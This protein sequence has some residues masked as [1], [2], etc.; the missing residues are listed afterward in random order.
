MKKINLLL[1]PLGIIALTFTSCTKEDILT[2]P[3]AVAASAAIEAIN[4]SDIQTGTQINYDNSG[5]LR[6]AKYTTSSCATIS[7]E[8]PTTTFPKTYIVDYGTGCT[9]NNITRKGKIKITFSNYITETGSTMTIQRVNYYVNDK[10]VEGKIVYK[11]TTTNATIPQW[12]RTVTDGKFTDGG[13]VFLNSGTHTTKQTAGASTLSLDDNTYE[14]TEGS[15]T[16]SKENESGI[17]LTVSEP[18]VK[19]HSCS[20]I[21]KGKLTITSKSLNGVIDYGNGDCDNKA[22]YTQGDVD[23]SITM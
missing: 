14:I 9:L 18:L 3:S 2:D 15:H 4:L 5:T 10:K 23:F 1:L 21:S 7:M 20:Y 19:N 12:T 13:V 16:V 6:A 8:T 11:N 17:T 22:T